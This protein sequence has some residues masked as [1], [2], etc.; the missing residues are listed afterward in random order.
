[1]PPKQSQAASSH[2]SVGGA[3]RSNPKPVPQQFYIP[4]NVVFYVC[5]LSNTLAASLAPIQDCDEVFNY[6]DPTHYLVHG[7]G[8]QTWE[9]SPEYSIRSWLYVSLHAGIAKLSTFVARSKAAQFYFV[10][11]ALA[12]MCTACE[13]RIYSAISRTLNPRIGVLFVMVMVFSPGMFHASAAMLPSS[14]TMYTSMLGVSAFMDWRGGMKTGRGIMW[15]GIG[16]ILGWPFAGA[17]VLPF[18][19][20][21]IA[22]GY[23]AKHLQGTLL[24]F[25]EGGIRCLIV[26]AVE[27]ATD[28]LYYRKL[29]VVPWNIVAYNV[30]GGSGKGPDIFGTEPW[31]FYFRN[32][33]LNFNV[34]FILA[35][36]VAPLLVFQ[37]L[38]RPHKT[39]KETL[40]RSITFILPFYMWLGIFTV[41][42]H[43]EERFMYPAYPFLALNAAIAFHIIL[44]YIGT[45]NPKELIGRIPPGVKLAIALIPVLL[46][47]NAGLLR[48]FGMVTAYNA[49][50]Q[51]F[52]PLENPTVANRGDFVCL[53]KEWYR[54]PSSFFLPGNKRAKFIKSEF[55]GLL[56]GEFKEADAHGLR[57]GTWT[58]PSGMNDQN[59]EDL[60]KYTNISQ[61]GFLI[62]SYFPGDE[63]SSLQPHY[64]KDKSTWEEL[65]CK[66]FL[67]TKRTGLI[68]RII[69]VPDLPFIPE[70]YQR[71]WGQYCLLGRRQVDTKP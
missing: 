71:K 53:G 56:P 17:L 49:P 51:I 2:G 40:L 54:F 61:C 9:Y 32:L 3:S 10:R 35:L 19:L 1:M 70:K 39:S 36:S 28:S 21:E 52:Q 43:K 50:L 15:F 47:T 29:V 13:T 55:D 31:T 68:G 57:P 11:M 33:L 69:W 4:L 48:D 7:Y 60:G 67:D 63:E 42:P 16:A 14:F 46:A 37:T 23:F 41:Q 66:K 6:W 58:V 64:I 34:W 12:F 30:F 65:S 8:L 45:S 27:V 44:S 18:L 22:V 59:H 24:R 5:L 20:E 25:I 62:D 26:L 38:L